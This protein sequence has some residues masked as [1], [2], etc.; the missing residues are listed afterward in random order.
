MLENLYKILLLNI[1]FTSSYIFLG[2]GLYFTEYRFD[3][4]TKKL[5]IYSQEDKNR[6]VNSKLQDKK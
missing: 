2:S 4:F 1:G 3:N 6:I 5:C